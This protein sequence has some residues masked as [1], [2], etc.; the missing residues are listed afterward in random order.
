MK[1]KRETFLARRLKFLISNDIMN[2]SNYNLKKNLIFLADI[3]R[4][5]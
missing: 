4:H 2:T 3:Y 5:Y 1:Q